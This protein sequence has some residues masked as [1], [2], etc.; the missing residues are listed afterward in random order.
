MFVFDE[1]EP[2]KVVDSMV[3]VPWFSTAIDPE[4]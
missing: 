3:V 2:A 4:T 1:T